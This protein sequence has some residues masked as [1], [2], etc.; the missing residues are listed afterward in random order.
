MVREASEGAPSI[1]IDLD[2]SMLLHEALERLTSVFLLG[3]RTRTD[4]NF[5]VQLTEPTHIRRL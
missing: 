5:R 2:S 3:V 1:P 4:G